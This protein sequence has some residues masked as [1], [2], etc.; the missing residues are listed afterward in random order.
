MSG[1]INWLVAK[2]YDNKIQIVSLDLEHESYK[3]VLLPKE[4]DAYTLHFYLGVLRDCL[5]V[6]I[7]HDV[8]GC[9]GTWK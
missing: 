2:E 3:E 7:G 4:V 8:L 6:V 1:T 5:C 9:E